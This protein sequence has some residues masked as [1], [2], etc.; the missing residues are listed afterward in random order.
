VTN[1]VLLVL[2]PNSLINTAKAAPEDVFCPPQKAVICQT[3]LEAAWEVD[4]LDLGERKAADEGLESDPVFECC[5]DP[6]AGEV[7]TAAQPAQ[8]LQLDR[9]RFILGRW[10]LSRLVID[11]L[12]QGFLCAD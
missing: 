3:E 11:F 9:V 1:R 7:G 8:G 4:G 10:L 6:F 12:V 5:G 2:P